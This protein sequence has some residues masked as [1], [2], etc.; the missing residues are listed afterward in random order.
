MPSAML[1]GKR[2][3]QFMAVIPNAVLLLILAVRQEGIVGGASLWTGMAITAVAVVPLLIL[4]AYMAATGRGRMLIAGFNTMTRDQQALYDGDR[5]ARAVGWFIIDITLPLL[6]GLS[7]IFLFRDTLVSWTAFIVMTVILFAILIYMNTGGR[8]LRDPGVKPKPSLN[9]SSRGRIAVVIAVIAVTAATIGGVYLL[10]QH[11]SVDVGLGDDRL[12][13]DAPS[14]NVSVAYADIESVELSYDLSK[15][16]RVMGF[17]GSKVS[18]G[19]FHN[20]LFGDY[21]LGSY[22]AVDLHIVVHSAGN[23]VLVFNQD[24]ADGTVALFDELNGRIEA[25]TTTDALNPHPE[26]FLV[27]AV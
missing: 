1:Q 8:Y 2:L 10:S 5:L 27:S 7:A 22:N 3:Y 12:S 9:I 21:D 23:R 16:S 26:P 15:G 18:S 25:L 19:L 17:G 14:L 6:I 13:V 24:S 4:G 20:S 11:G